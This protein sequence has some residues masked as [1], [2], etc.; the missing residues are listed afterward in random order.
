M[1]FSPHASSLYVCIVGPASGQKSRKS[2]EDGLSF[3]RKIPK[4]WQDIF[5]LYRDEF[6]RR[7]NYYH[8]TDPLKK[9]N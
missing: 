7:K 6:F 4:K 2:A 9:T 1:A 3:S 5:Y 8:N